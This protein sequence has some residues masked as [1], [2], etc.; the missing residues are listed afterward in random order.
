MN[1]AAL[2]ID[3]GTPRAR[4][5]KH[6][7]APER[8]VGKPARR[9]WLGRCTALVLLEQLCCALAVARKSREVLDREGIVTTGG[10]PHPLTRTLTDAQKTVLATLKALALD[11]EPLQPRAGRP[12]SR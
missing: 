11:I 2:P 12:V 10:K 6:L 4:P 1:V 9:V 3:R 5:P 8:D 7:E